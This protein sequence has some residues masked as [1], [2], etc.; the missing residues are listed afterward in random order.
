MVDVAKHRSHSLSSLDRKEEPG[1]GILSD[2][3][4]AS[5]RRTQ[6]S[7]SLL[8]LSQNISVDPDN[9]SQISLPEYNGTVVDSE[10]Y[11]SFRSNLSSSSSPFSSNQTSPIGDGELLADTLDEDSIVKSCEESHKLEPNLMASNGDV[12]GSLSNDT[13]RPRGMLSRSQ[14]LDLLDTIG[15]DKTWKS[16]SAE[17]KDMGNN[18]D[19]L[20]YF[21]GANSNVDLNNRPEDYAGSDARPVLGPLLLGRRMSTIEECYEE[22]PS[23]RSFVEIDRSFNNAYKANVWQSA[24]TT[25]DGSRDD[26]ELFAEP[27]FSNCW[28]KLGDFG[29]KSPV[30]DTKAFARDGFDK[31]SETHENAHNI[32]GEENGDRDVTWTAKDKCANGCQSLLSDDRS[33]IDFLGSE[34]VSCKDRQEFRDLSVLS[35]QVFDIDLDLY[36]I[37]HQR[38]KSLEI[39]LSDL[40]KFVD[41]IIADRQ[42]LE[43]DRLYLQETLQMI[44]GQRCSVRDDVSVVDKNDVC[45]SMPERHIEVRR[46]FAG[47]SKCAN[48]Q[49]DYTGSS[50]VVADLC[51]SESTSHIIHS[52]NSKSES[53][54]DRMVEKR[55]AT[56]T[57]DLEELLCSLEDALLENIELKHMNKDLTTANEELRGRIEQL[58]TDEEE[59]RYKLNEA[60]LKLMEDGERQ[61]EENNV[62]RNN[63]NKVLRDYN[64][65]EI[66]FKELE[67]NYEE[68]IV[69]RD[70]LAD[71]LA[72][73][74][75]DYQLCKDE[76]IRLTDELEHAKEELESYRKVEGRVWTRSDWEEW[77]V[78]Q[79]KISATELALFD[80]RK[81]KAQVV[82]D[83][84][85]LKKLLESGKEKIEDTERSIADLEKN[86]KGAQARNE[87]LQTENAELRYSIL[88][89][90]MKLAEFEKLAEEQLM[91]EDDKF[92]ARHF[93]YSEESGLNVDKEWV[94][95]KSKDIDD[96]RFIDEDELRM[97]EDN[98][99]WKSSAVLRGNEKSGNIRRARTFPLN[100][101]NTLALQLFQEKTL[102]ATDSYADSQY[103]NAFQEIDGENKE[104]VGD[105]EPYSATACASANTFAAPVDVE[106]SCRS[107][108]KKRQ[109]H[110]CFSLKGLLPSVLQSILTTKAKRGKHGRSPDK[111]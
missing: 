46:D 4:E 109:R 92:V 106:N 79:S 88:E 36:D 67:R 69:E 89:Y 15:Y 17:R 75:E 98:D 63:F 40:R 10:G 94:D 70:S 66:E 45:K 91:K 37:P 42:C 68:L 16:S 7:D 73:K 19:P 102:P 49:E 61:K 71:E 111:A 21:E 62:L 13:Q 25:V 33:L 12:P 9:Y 5:S 38:R 97:E 83:L 52:E 87:S 77:T 82:A 96:H 29:S 1:L 65:L 31:G 101:M 59:L 53:C 51:Y 90:E 86:L 23:P 81:Q 100:E 72:V 20:L 107:S 103:Q 57:A 11:S 43:K 48:H 26:R 78:L 41:R 3:V 60:T 108:V 99:V 76:C 64:S 95:I 34:S 58:L 105:C 93:R 47:T 74:N 35:D 39:K 32:V 14:E 30:K 110:P 18:Q 85:R 27:E 104:Y 55:S 56:S 8:S 28:S 80:A 84:K 6:S 22:T 2:L 24:S 54:D 50:R 44:E